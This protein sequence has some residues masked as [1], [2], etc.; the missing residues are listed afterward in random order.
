MVPQILLS[1]SVVTDEI[2]SFAPRALKHQLESQSLGRRY[3]QHHRA[4]DATR[5][6]LAPRQTFQDARLDLELGTAASV[7]MVHVPPELKEREDRNVSSMNMKCTILPPPLRN[8]YVSLSRREREV[9]ALVVAGRLNKQVGAELGIS[10]ITVKAHRGRM[11][12]KMNARTLPDLENM[13]A[14]LGLGSAEKR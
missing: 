9:M 12:H 1:V 7:W 3:R 10:E 8:C 13:V 4:I 11:M 6:S 5:P 2:D 14:K